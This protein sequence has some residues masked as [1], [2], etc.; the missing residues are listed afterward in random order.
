[1]AR[2]FDRPWMQLLAAYSQPLSTRN[3]TTLVAA[4]FLFQFGTGPV[5]GFAVTLAVGL[6]ANIFTATFVSRTL[7]SAILQQREVRRL[8]I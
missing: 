3:V 7:F 6:L 5:R 8:S 2:P 1:M 4:L